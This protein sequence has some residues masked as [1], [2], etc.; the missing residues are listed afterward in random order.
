MSFRK[1][2]EVLGNPNVPRIQTRAPLPERGMPPQRNPLRNDIRNVTSRIGGLSMRDEPEPALATPKSSQIDASHPGIRPSPATSQPTAA[3]GCH[4]LDKLLSHM[5]LPLGQLLLVQEQSATDFSSVIVKTFAAQGIVHNRIE[6]SNAFTKGNT[7]LVVLTLNQSFAKELPGV[8]QGSRKD[9]KRTKVS[10][11]ESE[12]T[13]QNTL[14]SVAL[15]QSVAPKDLKIA[16][17]YGLKDGSK[18]KG[19][20]KQN[21]DLDTF[22]N[23]SHTF[24]I[25]SRLVPAPTSA[26]LTLISPVQTLSMVLAQLKAVFKK[27]ERKVIRVVIPN[28]LHPAMYPPKYSQLSE[29]LPLLHGIRSIIKENGDRAVLLSTLSSDLYSNSG[30]QV[31]PMVEN[32]FDS[33]ISLEPFPQEMSQFLERVYKSQPNKIQHGL[34][35]V[36]KLPLL[37]DRGEMHVMRSEYAFRN[38]KKKFEIEPWGIPVDDSETSESNSTADPPSGQQGQTSVSIDF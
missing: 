18:S 22:P 1:R 13:V 15:K 35:H 2:S 17:R 26:E 9:V 14:E 6:G 28:L 8:Y 20:Q 37:S 29:L 24:D 23:Y 12:V 7:H 3:T 31:L 34:V 30:C 5:G 10:T 36:F 25:T 21:S 19:N 16:W 33:V 27:H 38:G 32:M 11:A 4:D